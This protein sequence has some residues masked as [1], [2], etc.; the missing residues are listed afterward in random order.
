MIPLKI[1]KRVKFRGNLYPTSYQ[2]DIS[3]SQ[4]LEEIIV[5]NNNSAHYFSKLN[6]K[7]EK[8]NQIKIKT[9]YYIMWFNASINSIRIIQDI[10]KN[11]ITLENISHEIDKN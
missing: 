2:V 7:S 8:F 3:I 9:P 11:N 6:P 5:I 10:L 4:Y 1:T